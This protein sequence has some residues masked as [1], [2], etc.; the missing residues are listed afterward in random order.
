MISCTLGSTVFCKLKLT[1]VAIEAHFRENLS[2]KWGWRELQ[3]GLEIC[4]FNRLPPR[5]SR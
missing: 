2:L 4:F 1:K 5:G 3:M